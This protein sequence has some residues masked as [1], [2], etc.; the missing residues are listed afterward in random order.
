MGGSGSRGFFRN[1]KP[2]EI[3]HDLRKEEEKTLNQAFDA[4]VAERLGEFL[5]EANRRD[6]KAIRDALDEINDALGAD[7]EGT[8][9]P[10]F[11]GSIRKHTY[12]D[13]ISDVDTLVILRDSKLKSLSPQQ[14]LAYFEQEAREK[15]S[16]W[17]ISRGNLAMTLRKE[18]LEIQILPAVHDEGKIYIPSARGDRWS[19]INPQP[20][21]RKLTETN[22]KLGGKV[23]PVIKL[24]K[25]INSQQPES[26]QLTGYHVESLAIEAF[27]G[28]ASPINPKAMLEHFFDRASALVLEPIQDKTGQS[29]HVD[30]YLGQANSSNRK[31]VSAALNRIHRRMKNADALRSE[32]QWL[33]P[34][35]E[36]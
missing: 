9:D 20:F 30:T 14:V 4:Q 26:L 2:E 16:G 27:K 34:F 32:E 35:G 17:E 15:L 33:E 13:G 24:A 11:G 19:D 1:R 23:V 10:I 28:Y 25:I 8:I 36:E 12:V 3:K 5:S 29:V 21:F 31:E 6:A 18:G 7:I 22:N